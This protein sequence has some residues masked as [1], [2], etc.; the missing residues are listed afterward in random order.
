MSRE[1]RGECIPGVKGMFLVVF[2]LSPQAECRA[3]KRSMDQIIN[4]AERLVH[5]LFFLSQAQS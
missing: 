3:E 1:R 2:L 5:R 4:C